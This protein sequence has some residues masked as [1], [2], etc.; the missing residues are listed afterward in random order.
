[1]RERK[2]KGVSENAEKNEENKEEHPIYSKYEARLPST[3]ISPEKA[4]MGLT[5]PTG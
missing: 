3:M 5:E 4:S 2:R 1:M